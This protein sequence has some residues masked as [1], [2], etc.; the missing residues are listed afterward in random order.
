MEFFVTA[1]GAVFI[2]EISPR[3]HNSGH[4]T[5]DAFHYGQ[6]E[7]H[8]RAVMG[9]PLAPIV[10]HAPAAVMINLLYDERYAA[11]RSPSPYSVSLEGPAP[12]MLH[13]YGKRDARPGRKMGHVN[14]LGPSVEAAERHAEAG[15]AKLCHASRPDD[16]EVQQEV[17]R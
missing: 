6:F 17:P 16:D 9:L 7:Q 11:L 13:W 1:E 8:V 3:V 2:N 12:A 15:L 4:V 10:P 5:M 14:A